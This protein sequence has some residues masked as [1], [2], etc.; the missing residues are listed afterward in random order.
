M[1]LAVRASQRAIRVKDRRRVV[2]QPW[3]R[4]FKQGRDDDNA[5]LTRQRREPVGRRS[6][7]R[8]RQIKVARLHF[9]AEVGAAKELRQHTD[10][11]ALGRRSA[12]ARDRAIEVIGASR[13]GGELV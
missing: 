1:R 10:V 13:I 3:H 8:F 7:D 9:L 6:R 5:K 12:H 11:G 4:A 2:V